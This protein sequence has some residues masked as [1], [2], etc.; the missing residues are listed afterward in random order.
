MHEHKSEITGKSEDI[1]HFSLEQKQNYTYF[2]D[3]YYACNNTEKGI[4]RI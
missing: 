4:I 3:L 2:L 1:E